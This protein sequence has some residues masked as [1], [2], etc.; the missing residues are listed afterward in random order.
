MAGKK[1]KAHKKEKIKHYYL[2][3]KDKENKSKRVKSHEINSLRDMENKK[4]RLV[5]RLKT[6]KVEASINETISV[7]RKKLHPFVRKPKLISEWHELRNKILKSL[8]F[9]PETKFNR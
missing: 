1:P 7:L 8:G 3:G 6:F 9:K 5:S 2:V 4:K